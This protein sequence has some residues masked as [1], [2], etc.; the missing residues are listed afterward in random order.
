MHHHLQTLQE[1][2]QFLAVEILHNANRRIIDSRDIIPLPRIEQLKKVASLQ[3]TS[4]RNYIQTPDNFRSIIARVRSKF[5]SYG[6]NVRAKTS[7]RAHAQERASGW[8]AL[9][10][11]P[12]HEEMC[13]KQAHCR[14]WVK[15]FD[16][17]LNTSV[18]LRF[19]VADRDHAVLL[20]CA[21]C[22]Q[23]QSKLVGMR[24]YR[25]FS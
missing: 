8:R 4:G 14:K 22:S 6:C 16:K 23:F 18:R 1:E 12:T 20:S 7:A 9:Y 3:P 24:N 19:E 25:A 13:G 2:L 15:G 11:R 5:M 17:T 21:V 10:E